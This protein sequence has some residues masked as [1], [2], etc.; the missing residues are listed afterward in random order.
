MYRRFSLVALCAVTGCAHHRAT[1][2]PLAAGLPQASGVVV[3]TSID[4]PESGS[5]FGGHYTGATFDVRQSSYQMTEAVRTRWGRE[6]R[7]RGEA[8][9]RGAGIRV[10]T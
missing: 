8:I 9:L 2:A 3:L 10:H 7:L 6:A 5:I 1:D 4:L